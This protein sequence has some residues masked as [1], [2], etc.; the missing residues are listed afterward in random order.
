VAGA[1]QQETAVLAVAATTN[2]SRG[3]IWRTLCLDTGRCE[4]LA[5]AAADSSFGRQ[6]LLTSCGTFEAS[7]Q[8]S[9]LPPATANSTYLPVALS[10]C[11]LPRRHSGQAAAPSSADDLV[12]A[13]T[14]DW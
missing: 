7:C 5:G 6:L 12:V 8:R 10:R 13:P 3:L 1:T 9:W 2:M 11:C 14:A 4:L